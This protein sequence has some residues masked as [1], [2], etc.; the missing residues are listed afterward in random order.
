MT[1]DEKEKAETGWKEYISG[2]VRPWEEVKKELP[3]LKQ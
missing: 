1:K 2:E 3:E